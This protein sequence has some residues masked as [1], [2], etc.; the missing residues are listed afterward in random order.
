MGGGALKLEKE[1]NE[2]IGY[3]ETIMQKKAGTN[4]RNKKVCL[5]GRGGGEEAE[6]L[7]LV[8]INFF[9]RKLPNTITNKRQF[10]KI[11][12]LCHVCEIK[13]VCVS[14]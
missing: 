2:M 10:H 5:A 13:C 3:G 1:N 11:S 9:L 7:I 6:E 4:K 14:L 8:K 12:S